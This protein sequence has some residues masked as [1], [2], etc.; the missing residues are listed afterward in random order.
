MTLDMNPLIL[1]RF[2]A[3]MGGP[4][5]LPLD[6]VPSVPNAAIVCRNGTELVSAGEDVVTQA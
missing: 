3:S 2:Q 6:S 4:G 5:F 1:R